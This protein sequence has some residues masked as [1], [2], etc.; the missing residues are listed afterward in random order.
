MESRV[1][2]REIDQLSGALGAWLQA[3]GLARER[4]LR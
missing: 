2:F 3:K 4:A 1:T